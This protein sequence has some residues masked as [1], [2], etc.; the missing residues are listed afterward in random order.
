MLPIRLELKNFLAYVQPDPIL[1]ENLHLA[2]LVGPNG[3]GK[4]SLL[5]AITWALWG[6]ARGRSDD[7]L[8][9]QGQD[10]MKVTLDFLHEGQKYR[11]SRERKRGK[12]SGGQ[13]TLNLY[14]W[15]SGR[16]AF[17]V[18]TEPSIRET[19]KRLDK[20]LNLTYDT[21]T[22]SA[23]LQQG[24]A[25]AFTLLTA[26]ERKD[27]LGEILGLKQ[28]S[29]YEDLAKARYK[30]LNDEMVWN[31]HAIRDIEGELQHEA[32]RQRDL[33]EA[34]AQFHAATQEL[35]KAE[36]FLSEVA[37][38]DIELQAA[39]AHLRELER[40]L[41]EQ[42]REAEEAVR[43][44]QRREGRLAELEA[45]LAESEAIQRGFA[46]LESAR[47]HDASLGD[48]LR[49]L[50][51]LNQQVSQ[52]ERQLDAERH[53]LEATLRQQELLLS[54]ESARLEEAQK[55]QEALLRLNEDLYR[56]EGLEKEREIKRETI[57]RLNQSIAELNGRNSALEK[58][59]KDLK[60]KTQLLE[61]DESATCP[62]CG[63]ALS[64]A[65]RQAIIR[66]NNEQ[67]EAWRE[68]Y[69]QNRLQIVTWEGEIQQ[70]KNW[71]EEASQQLKHMPA[72]RAQ[73]GALAQTLDQAENA[74]ENFL[75]LQEAIISLKRTLAENDFAHALRAELQSLLDEQNR[76]GYDREQHEEVRQQL[77]QFQAFQERKMRLELAA[78]SKPQAEELLRDSQARYERWGAAM[79][80]TQAEIEAQS[81]TVSDLRDKVDE[82][83]RRQEEVNRQRTLQRQADEKVMSAQQALK[84]LSERR[85]RREQLIERQARLKDEASY[86]DQLKLAFSVKGIPAMLIEAAIP[87]LEEEANRLLK[88]MTQNRMDLR[89]VTQREKKDESGV[90][91][92]LDIVIQD[93]LGQRDYALY[94]GGEAFRVNFSIRIALSQLLARRAGAKLRTLFIDEGF[95]TQDEVGREQLVE[96]ITAIQDD[97]DLILVI[98]HIDDL[99]DAFPTRIEVHKTP[100]GS[101]V[102]LM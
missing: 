59:A 93:E 95:G 65:K 11:I 85:K 43:D 63:Q 87:E 89:F 41:R 97:F 1:L 4:T 49:R 34:Q 61:E 42:E 17:S 2:C 86:Y 25:D 69:R 72:L 84:A 37:G 83:R 23:F 9:H 24:K 18:I 7:D 19:Q 92:T 45:L 26:K 71:L 70:I 60:Q 80:E 38:A 91:E 6:K 29:I 102:R 79:R 31:A 13:S 15:E 77:T 101:R 51:D 27:F 54:Q 99:K 28:W 8:I 81:Q 82:M 47:Q 48:K 36:S 3:A 53:A 57:N 78:Q 76:L 58:D 32:A 39:Q 98:T 12:K 35:E 62:T 16:N 90:I 44:I 94:S 67:V 21:F 100:Q 10:E 52:L 96:A 46:E 75:R 64:P 50:T 22:T 74:Q 40:R 20:L 33:S 56:L 66:Q 68:S 55:A 14:A 30:A 88:R 73:R 5:D